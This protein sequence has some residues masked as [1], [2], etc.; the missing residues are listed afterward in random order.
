M[1]ASAYSRAAEAA[2]K[3]EKLPE[4]D[5]LALTERLAL[6]MDQLEAGTTGA[7]V[8]DGTEVA[9]RLEA[10]ADLKPLAAQPR[11]RPSLSPFGSQQKPRVKA[12]P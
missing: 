11:F 4:A 2:S 12:N 8:L 10:D 3:D 9:D 5:R 1:L 7:G 6:A